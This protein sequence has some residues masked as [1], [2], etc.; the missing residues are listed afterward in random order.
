MNRQLTFD[1]V[2][3]HLLTQGEKAGSIIDGGGFKCEYRDK[4]GKSCAIGCL[5][6][7]GHKALNFALDVI[8]LLIEFPEFKQRWAVEIDD[9]F[10]FLKN[11]QSV[12]DMDLVEDWKMKLQTV[13][14]LYGLN[15]LALEEF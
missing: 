11:L 12:H 1:T 5:I 4:N 8:S 13:A 7:N 2:S 15:Q 10:T 6:P 3:R 14:N 9:D